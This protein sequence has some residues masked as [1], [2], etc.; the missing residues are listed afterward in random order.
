MDFFSILVST[1]PCSENVFAHFCCIRSFLCGINDNGEEFFIG[2]NIVPGPG[3]AAFLTPGSRMGKNQ[4]PG[5]SGS[6]MNNPDHISESLETV[7]KFLM[8]IRD[9]VWKK[10]GIRDK[11]PGSATLVI[12]ETGEQS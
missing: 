12:N 6:G 11:H 5:G 4:D 1:T 7:L 9:P 8:R 10:F 3:S 2:Y